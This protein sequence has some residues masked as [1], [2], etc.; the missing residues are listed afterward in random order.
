MTVPFEESDYLGSPELA[1][2]GV[3]LLANLG[4][5]ISKSETTREP[6]RVHP[7]PKN[8]EGAPEKCA[9]HT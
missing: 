2:G 3:A 9:M 4:F 1:A 7:I 5:D 6:I 8:V